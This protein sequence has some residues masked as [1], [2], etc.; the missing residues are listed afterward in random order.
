LYQ[1]VA[2]ALVKFHNKDLKVK[3]RGAKDGKVLEADENIV[4]DLAPML[5]ASEE[6]RIIRNG[7][8]RRAKM[9][10]LWL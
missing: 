4:I 6:F 8:L 9:A 3:L 7:E 1:E 5:G 2:V 10:V